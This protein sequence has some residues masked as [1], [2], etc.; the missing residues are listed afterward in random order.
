MKQT[1][2][3]TS[4]YWDKLYGSATALAICKAAAEHTG[5]V[6]VIVPDMLTSSHLTHEL[7]FFVPSELPIL[8]LPDWETLPYDRFSPHQDIISERLLTLYQLLEL[9]KGILITTVASTMQR[10]VPQSYLTNNSFVL[11]KS[12][13]I[14]LIEL[15]NSLNKKGY[16]CVNQVMEH[17]EYSIRGELIDLFPMG[18]K[19]PYRID[20]FD[21]EVESIREFD[22]ETQRSLQEIE[23]IHLLPARECPLDPTSIAKFSQKWQEHFPDKTDSSPLYQNIVSG[24]SAP[25]IEYYLPLFF[26]ATDTI[27]NYFPNNG[28]LISINALHE[29]AETFW[30]ELNQRYEQLHFDITRPLLPPV[31]LFLTV[32]QLFGQM[33][34][35]ARIQIDGPKPKIG[36]INHKSQELPDLTI[37]SK[38]TKPLAKLE[39]FVG[40]VTNQRILFCAESAGRREALLTLLKRINLAPKI[41]SGWQDFLADTTPLGICLGK[42]D[43]GLW[44]NNLVLIPET[45]LFGQ[46]TVMQRRLRKQKL[47]DPEAIVRDLTE[48]KIGDPVVHIEHGIGRYLGLETISTADSVGEYLSLEYADK[49]KLYVPI[50]SLHLISRYMGA[51]PENAPYNSLGSKQWEKAKRKAQEKIHDVAVELLDIYARRAAKTG[52]SCTISLPEYEKF[53]GTFPFE[54]TPDQQNAIKQVLEDMESNRTMDR[55]ICGDVGFGKTE[56]ALRAAFIAASNNKQVAILTPTTLLTQQHY[57]NFQDRFADWPIKIA[58]LSR[59]NS[60][61][62]QKEVVEGLTNGTVD[63]VIGTHKLLQPDIIFKNLGLLIVD[64]E[65]RFGVKQKERIKS[66]RSDID[67]LTLTATPIPRTLNMSLTGI[68]DLSIIATPPAKRRAIKT[69]V[70]DYNDALIREA[71][72]REIMRGGQ[73]YFLHNDVATIERTVQTLAEIVPEAKIK[74]AHGQMHERQLENIMTDFYHLR[75]NLLV[76]TTIIESGID[77]P[78]ANTIIINNADN[79][80]LA[81]LHQLRGRVG[82]SHHQAYSYLLVRSKEN[83]KR[84]AEKRLDAIS[85]ME[86]L[87][88][89]F[90]LATHDLEIRGAGEIL[91]EEQSGQIHAIGFNLYMEFLEQAVKALK[92]GKQPELAEPLNYG[93]E[94]EL[95]IP[96]LIPDD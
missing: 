3:K 80:G 83:L 85:S 77:I 57:N 34:N 6:V 28:L 39:N 7:S 46:E 67:I 38:A 14:D 33:K 55:L 23:K 82:R 86:D 95:Q 53:S 75:F 36:I 13:E 88:A 79:F 2:T 49:A 4:T 21:N 9:K 18:S 47:A 35:F 17:G 70:H 27:L 62:E 84:D 20:L 30:H 42:L 91:G 69:F 71:V 76:C 74:F 31:N 15:R 32:D 87:G 44:Q 73:V 63:I 58:M 48:L 92:A 25:G 50:A 5:P 52:F 12:E 22:P 43:R 96:A 72:L 41:Y 26:D 1:D 90:T 19:V 94:I 16:Y 78:T 93:T 68:R 40:S 37:E 60:K 89:G 10:L 61:T 54:T 56:V 51:S 24:Q 29:P 66:H 64:E 8:C 65:H 81:N 11:S 59:F 45:V